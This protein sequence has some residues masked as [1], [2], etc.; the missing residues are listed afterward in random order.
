MGFITEEQLDPVNAASSGGGQFITED[1]LDP[2]K[3]SVMDLL[4]GD[5]A[6]TGQKVARMG[7]GGISQFLP[8]GDEIVAGGSALVDKLRGSESLGDSY[9]A[10]LK[11]VRDYQAAFNK[12]SDNYGGIAAPAVKLG[13]ALALPGGLAKN[14]SSLTGK[15]GLTALEG[16]AVGGLYGADAAEGGLEQR[17]QGAKEGA[18]SGAALSAAIGAPLLAAEKFLPALNKSGKALQRSSLGAKASDYKKGIKDLGV[19]DII[20]DQVEVPVKKV[21]DDLAGRPE[22]GVSRNPEKLLATVIEKEK[23]LG[24]E[25]GGV[26]KA[27][28]TG[29]I[30]PK[31]S[32]TK[33]VLDKGE[34]PAELIPKFQQ[35][36]VSLDA[37]IKQY[38]EGSLE[39]LQQQKIAYGSRWDA[40]N[41]INNKF[42]RAVY[43]DLQKTIEKAAP[44]IKPLNNE[45]SKWKTLRKI[46]E[47]SAA[48][49]AASNPV[50]AT[51]QALRTS[52]GFLTSPALLGS[53][54]GAGTGGPIGAALG[55]GLGAA[56]TPAGKNAVGKGLSVLS[57]QGSIFGAIGEN[58]PS[59]FGRLVGDQSSSRGSAPAMNSIENSPISSSRQTTQTRGESSTLDKRSKESNKLSQVPQNTPEDKFLNTLLDSIKTVESGGNNKA[60]SPAGAKG[61]YQFTDATA[62]DYGLEDPFNEPEAR[63]AALRKVLADWEKFGDLRLALAAYNAG[64]G[65]VGKLLKQVDGESYEDI[66]HLLPAETKAYVPKIEKVFAKLMG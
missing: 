18:T 63:D 2:V 21:L 56:N 38:G 8:F 49:D 43:Q 51:M 62:K 61:P 10:R 44:E 13:G 16:G 7:V 57:K 53:A 55:A 42:Y 40:G 52:G 54:I 25:I 14:A 32:R 22:L 41:P 24:D 46:V 5:D 12:Q 3:G 15:I 65:R 27:N 1:M 35:D 30:F 11:E 66:A 48:V 36:V 17:L 47:G 60:I 33:E 31:W 39:F 37:A 20:D 23:A 9:D 59:I 29:G 28:D 34:L 4:G 58:V 50:K 19:W 45:L 64:A 26:I 6:S